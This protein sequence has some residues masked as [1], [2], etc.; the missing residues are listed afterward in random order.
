VAGLSVVIPT[1]DRAGPLASTLSALR[2]QEGVG[3]QAEIV[4]V[5]NGSKDDTPQ[6]LAGAVN[7]PGLPLRSL[8]EPR[9]G[10][11]AAR[12]AGVRAASGD[13]VLFLGDDV[14]PAG[15]GLLAG[16]LGAPRDGETGVLGRVRWDPAKPIT[17][18]MEWLDSSG[19]Q[20]D[21]AGLQPGPVDPVRHLYTAN[22]SLPKAL[23]LEV[24]GF[25]ERFTTAAVED[26]ELGLRLSRRGFKLSYHPALEVLHDHYTTYADSLRRTER[27]GAAA[28]CFHT[29]HGRAAHPAVGRPPP[30]R[31]GALR[32]A[33]ALLAGSRCAP[34]LPAP[35]RAFRWRVA[36][37]AAFARGLSEA[38]RVGSA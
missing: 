19:V 18:F 15:P 30:V 29:I 10:P 36:H 31:R 27:V 23:L 37:S 3:G 17:T 35:V 2:A 20:F 38:E 5:D 28:A 26:L 1:R 16:H 24:G 14:R 32:A 34:G 11:A 9:P 21:Y 25:D 8:R 13:L 6:L 12:N 22:V 7:Q 33:A 4:V